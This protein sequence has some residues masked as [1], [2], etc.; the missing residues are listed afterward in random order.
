MRSKT[1]STQ[2]CCVRALICRATIQPRRISIR[3]STFSPEESNPPRIQLRNP[4][5]PQQIDLEPPQARISSRE[6]AKPP[7]VKKAPERGKPDDSGKRL[8]GTIILTSLFAIGVVVGL[9]SLV[10]SEAFQ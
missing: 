6:T 4:D 3:L 7:T 10:N 2:E 8:F 1:L 5:M 9:V